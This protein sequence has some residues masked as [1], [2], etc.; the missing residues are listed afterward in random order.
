MST[1]LTY[2]SSQFINELIPGIPTDGEGSRAFARAFDGFMYVTAV[3]E[4]D[5]VTVPENNDLRFARWSP[6]TGTQDMQW[7][8]SLS[9]NG[10][11]LDMRVL[12]FTGTP[13]LYVLAQRVPLSGTIHWIRLYRVDGPGQFTQIGPNIPGSSAGSFTPEGALGQFNGHVYVAGDGGIFKLEESDWSTE[14]SGEARRHH[15]LDASDNYLYFIRGVGTLGQQFGRLDENDNA[16][17]LISSADGNRPQRAM[18]VD[19]ETGQVFLTR[20]IGA[21]HTYNGQTINF[22]QDDLVVYNEGE[23][24]FTAIGKADAGGVV[25]GKSH[26]AIIEIGGVRYFVHNNAWDEFEPSM[27]LFNV[28][29]HEATHVFGG[30]FTP[31]TNNSTT[32]Q[33]LFF[34][35]ELYR[36]PWKK[37]QTPQTTIDIS[38]IEFLPT[39]YTPL[40]DQIRVFAAGE[41]RKDWE[42]DGTLLT[43]DAELGLGDTLV[44][45]RET[46]TDRSWVNFSPTSPVRR[47]SEMNTYFNQRLYI[48]QELCEIADVADLIGHPIVPSAFPERDESAWT[49]QFAG[50]TPNVN[51][52][53]FPVIESPAVPIKNQLEVVGVV[54]D[55]EIAVDWSVDSSGDIVVPTGWNTEDW[56]IRVKRKTRID[57]FWHI[58]RDAGSFPSTPVIQNHQQLSFLMEESCGVPTLPDDHP[59]TNTIFPRGLNWLLYVGPGPRFFFGHMPWAGDGNIFVYVNGVLLDDDEWEFDWESWDIVIPDLNPGDQVTFGPGGSSSIDPGGLEFPGSDETD[60]TVPPGP[61]PREPASVCPVCPPGMVPVVESMPDNPLVLVAIRCEGEPTGE[62]AECTAGNLCGEGQIMTK[63]PEDD[64][65]FLCDQTPPGTTSAFQF[66]FTNTG[67]QGETGF[68]PAGWATGH[69]LGLRFDHPEDDRAYIELYRSTCG[70]GE[71]EP[72]GVLCRVRMWSYTRNADGDWSWSHSLTCSSAVTGRP[73]WA[74]E[75]TDWWKDNTLADNPIR[76]MLEAFDDTTFTDGEQWDISILQQWQQF[77]QSAPAGES[78]PM[79][80]FQEWLNGEP[81]FDE[82]EDDE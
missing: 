11:L 22:D 82:D 56:P 64:E 62:L 27:T 72:P 43:V 7:Q 6:E 25:A 2:R 13:H 57:R 5:G 73:A 50:D 47:T 38:G 71:D 81:V 30:D 55:L 23:D 32:E 4:L 59:L 34:N 46:R 15:R 48:L 26:G 54:N 49:M 40:R 36:M 52:L 65:R 75:I 18:E 42:L 51:T 24:T 68:G 16:E 3:E 41:E 44:A 78:V 76:Q 39:S 77:M 14:L 60:V 20:W 80:L 35:S 66:E 31:N 70:C 8:D 28:E 63:D 69:G 67:W 53:D 21:E 29:T 45:F 19:K 9:N 10:R 61:V 1:P 12:D 37:V 58:M 33:P 17:I 74:N 79:S